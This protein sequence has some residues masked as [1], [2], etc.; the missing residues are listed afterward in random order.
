MTPFYYEPEKVWLL[1]IT[2]QQ[3]DELFRDAK[4]WYKTNLRNSWT[5]DSVKNNL[6]SVDGPNILYAIEVGEPDT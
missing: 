2:L 6:P 1:P 3:A 4:L 5:R